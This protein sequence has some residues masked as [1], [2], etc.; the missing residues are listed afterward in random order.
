MTCQNGVRVVQASTEGITKTVGEPFPHLIARYDAFSEVIFSLLPSKDEPALQG[1]F[2]E[3]LKVHMTA[4]RHNTKA[5]HH[6]T[7]GYLSSL[8]RFWA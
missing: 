1:N 6:V 5:S 2:A 8:R 3:Q 7:A 4:W